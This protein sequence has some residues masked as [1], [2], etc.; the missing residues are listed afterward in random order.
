[1]KSPLCHS[2]R[3]RWMR[4]M[5]LWSLFVM[6]CWPAQG[7]QG[8]VQGITQDE[9]QTWARI[10]V[11]RGRLSVDLMQADIQAVLAS[12]AEQ[13]GIAITGEPI[14]E[15]AISI[16]F[17]DMDLETGLRRLLQLAFLNYTILYS[18]G[19]AGTAAIK[20][21]YVFGEK[22]KGEPQPPVVA[23]SDSNQNMENSDPQLVTPWSLAPQASSPPL[24]EQGA[25]EVIQRL[26]EFSRQAEQG[27][28]QGTSPAAERKG[29]DALDVLYK[30][31]ERLSN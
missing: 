19:G 5:A 3:G 30:A 24:R 4:E 26:Q 18:Q 6:A 27:T 11:D 17:T 12:I 15:R 16:L 13:A 7:P 22:Q 23:E 20:E 31:F 1:M 2:S 9:P 25:S 8:G 14:G 21:V 28:P 10:A 29:N